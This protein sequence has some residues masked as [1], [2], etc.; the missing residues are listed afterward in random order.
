MGTAVNGF[1]N[2]VNRQP[3][4]AAKGDF[5]DANVRMNVIARAGGFVAAAAPDSPIVGNF[6]WGE[7]SGSNLA[8]SAFYGSLTAKLGFV[9]KENNAVIVPW[10]AA[11]ELAIE[12]GNIVTLFD[13]GSFW[14]EFLLGAS[15]GQKVFARYVDGSTYAAPAGTSNVD[16]STRLAVDVP[17]P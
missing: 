9:H 13:R 7:Q 1:Q 16:V 14:A 4:P 10:L 15:V 12:H 8:A 11:N 17:A 3:A 5:A 2:I 6:A